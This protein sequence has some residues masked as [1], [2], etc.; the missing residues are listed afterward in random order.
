MLNASTD[1][2]FEPPDWRRQGVARATII[3]T[4]KFLRDEKQKSETSLGVVGSNQAAI[5]LYKSLGY[6]LIDIHLL[7]VKDIV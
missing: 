2:G 6:E 5:R 3:E 4:M 7:M 1:F